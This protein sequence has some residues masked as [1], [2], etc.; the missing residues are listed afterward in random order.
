VLVVGRPVDFLVELDMGVGSGKQGDHD[1]HFLDFHT[2]VKR[3]LMVLFFCLVIS[4]VPPPEKFSADALGVRS[5]NL[6]VC[7]YSFSA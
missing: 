3:C 4:I 1:F 5:E 7:I 6:K 2:K